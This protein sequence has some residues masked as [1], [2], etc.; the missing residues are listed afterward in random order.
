M[1]RILTTT[2]AAL[3]LGFSGGMYFQSL[4]ADKVIHNLKME[5][6]EEHRQQSELA[7]LVL[8]EALLET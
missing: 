8:E 3:A 6:A 2:I 4:R 7:S 1:V 5:Y